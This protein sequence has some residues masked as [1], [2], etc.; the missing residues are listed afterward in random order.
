MTSVL[1]VGD[2]TLENRVLAVLLDSLPHLNVVGHA[3]HSDA[4]RMAGRLAPHLVVWRLGHPDLTVLARLRR[5]A[6][7]PAAPQVLILTGPTPD[8]YAY[9][10]LRAGAGGVLRDTATHGQL[11]AA[12]RAV[13]SGGAALPPDTTRRFIDAFRNLPPPRRIAPAATAT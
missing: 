5:I 10:L 7:A 6:Q 1:L 12:V 11:L 4:V 3:P 2:P 8:H 13:T 9:T